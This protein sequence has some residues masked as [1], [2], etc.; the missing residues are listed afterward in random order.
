MCTVDKIK[1]V[2]VCRKRLHCTTNSLAKETNQQ[3]TNRKARN[4]EK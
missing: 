3:S 1:D 2:G 4:R